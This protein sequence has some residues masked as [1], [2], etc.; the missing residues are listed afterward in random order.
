M[1][2]SSDFE[3][4]VFAVVDDV[5]VTTTTTTTARKIDSA[6]IDANEL[7]TVDD[8]TREDSTVDDAECDIVVLP[9]TDVQQ[10]VSD[11]S[12]LRVCDG[13]EDDATVDDAMD[14]GHVDNDDDDD[15]DDDGGASLSSQTDAAKLA[16]V[17]SDFDSPA[18]APLQYDD[19]SDVVIDEPEENADALP[20]KRRAA[21][22]ASEATRFL[23]TAPTAF[24][25]AQGASGDSN[26]SSA[27]ARRLAP[28][29]STGADNANSSSSGG[30]RNVKKAT[31]IRQYQKQVGFSVGCKLTDCLVCNNGVPPDLDRKPPP[32][33]LIEVAMF[34]LLCDQSGIDAILSGVVNPL[35]TPDDERVWF[36][37]EQIR[38]FL[39]HH[40]ASLKQS[41][42]AEENVLGG[43]FLADV[44]RTDRRFRV[45]EDRVT[46]LVPRNIYEANVFASS[47]EAAPTAEMMDTEC[48]LCGQQGRGNGHWMMVRRPA[49]Y[50]KPKPK[51]RKPSVAE[52]QQQQPPPPPPPLPSLAV[53]AQLEGAPAAAA[54][55]PEML[56]GDWAHNLCL[57]YA[58]R[59]PCEDDTKMVARAKAH[60]LK[61]TACK[62]PRATIGCC[63]K[64]CKRIYHQQCAKLNGEWHDGERAFYCSL[65]TALAVQKV[66]ELTRF[67]H[68]SGIE[69][70]RVCDWSNIAPED[71]AKIDAYRYCWQA[72]GAM[73]FGQNLESPLKVLPIGP[74]HWAYS[75][76]LN[77]NYLHGHPVQYEVVASRD[78]EADEF[79]GEYVGTVCYQDGPNSEYVAALYWPDGLPAELANRQLVIDAADIGNET[80]Y[81]NSVNDETAHFIQRNA[82]M[83]TVWC[84]GRLRVLITAT[85]NVPKGHPIV[86]DYEE[87]GGSFF[88]TDDEDDAAPHQPPA[89][90][91][92]QQTEPLAIDLNAAAESSEL[93]PHVAAA[94]SSDLLPHVAAESCEQAPPPQPLAASGGGGNGESLVVAPEFDVQIYNQGMREECESGFCVALDAVD[95]FNRPIM[96]ENVIE[97][98]RCGHYELLIARMYAQEW[99]GGD[100]VYVAKNKFKPLV[101]KK[102]RK[103]QQGE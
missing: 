79:L 43:S 102:R 17:V 24:M 76:Y 15:D 87:H 94:E 49:N 14:G 63:E 77:N 8:A 9:H 56:M 60:R 74:G 20:K 52:P 85:R 100:P 70:R 54:A 29:V 25:V 33:N 6:A 57:Y 40:W 16:A 10:R 50:T 64:T 66:S 92:A 67:P 41:T 89:A 18:K 13:A 81:I 1:S 44:A 2:V 21:V 38:D 3:D 39:H 35:E 48:V 26:G 36:T 59:L 42:L 53:E 62:E 45:Q 11:A 46:L 47:P 86:L 37:F 7:S 72:F 12:V 32:A 19:D 4:K 71:I 91:A 55:A 69:Y 93:L 103:R 95:V 96:D 58:S 28:K 88:D 101:A 83:N 73:W 99:R 31:L 80:R 98:M 34:A 30:K 97:E 22:K 51:G 90:A 61:C 82:T 84:N 23:A 75:G 78:I 68:D 27:R 65:H 5:T